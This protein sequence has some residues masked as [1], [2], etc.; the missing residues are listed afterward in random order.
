MLL[1]MPECP[2]HSEVRQKLCLAFKETLLH[3]VNY[4]GTSQV[5]ISFQFEP[6]G[7]SLAVADNGSGFD[8]RRG[9]TGPERSRPA[10]GNGLRNIR[11][12]LAQIQGRTE[13]HSAP[14][15]GTR[16]EF[17]VPMSDLPAAP[18]RND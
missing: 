18:S 14:G 13:I 6:G 9:A 4:S 10:P 11:S 2:V 8:S 15:E 5:C 7:F 12:R 3:A 1:Q 16:V 17:F